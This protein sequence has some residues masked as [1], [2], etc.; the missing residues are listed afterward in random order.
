MSTISVR[1]YGELNDHLPF[2]VRGRS[3]NVLLDGPTAARDVIERLGVPH[4]EVELVLRNGEPIGFDDPVA[5]ADRLAAYPAFRELDLAATTRA[6]APVPESPRFILDGH[7]GRLAA[8]LRLLGYDAAH[9]VPGDDAALAQRSADE[10]RVLLTRDRGLL[11]R[12]VVEHGYWLRSQQPEA[13]LDEV[14][15]RFQLQRWA[16]PFTR[17]L[18][19]N[20]P[21]VV[22][23]S[24]DVGELLPADVRERGLPLRRCTGCQQLYWEGAHQRRLRVLVERVMG[25]PGTKS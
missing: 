16:R 8:Y 22:V 6:G 5:P 7:L 12:G 17:C 25:A 15:Q 13:Q 1:V 10:G 9:E 18:K 20:H 24:V 21:L 14:A 23:R 3:M 2:L 19:C 11:K 4:V